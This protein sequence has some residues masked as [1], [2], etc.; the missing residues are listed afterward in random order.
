MLEPIQKLKLLI[1]P[2]ESLC[3]DYLEIA[4]KII[5]YKQQFKYK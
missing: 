5:K 2:N 4:Q 3:Q 1:D